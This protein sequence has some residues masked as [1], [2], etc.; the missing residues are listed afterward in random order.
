M[1][2]MPQVYPMGVGMGELIYRFYYHYH[3]LG[4]VAGSVDVP[5]DDPELA[6]PRGV[7]RLF[8]VRPDGPP[9][10]GCRLADQNMQLSLLGPVVIPELRL[11]DKGLI[12]VSRFRIIPVL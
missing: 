6:A 1:W 8:D 3:S 7:D 4:L 5:L 2:E 11:S 12:D 10:C 9:L